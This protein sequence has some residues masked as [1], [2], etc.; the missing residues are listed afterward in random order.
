MK[1]KL[2]KFIRRA[3][4]LMGWIVPGV[5]LALVPKCPV[6][7]AAYIAVWT[8]IGLSLSVA[9]CLRVSLMVVSIALILFFAVRS[10]RP[11]IRKFSLRRVGWFHEVLGSRDVICR[12]A[13]SKVSPGLSRGDAWVQRRNHQAHPYA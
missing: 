11:L 4:D 13:C 8:G 2:P 1:T 5:V 6:C 7:F 10:A 12:L 3:V 9:T